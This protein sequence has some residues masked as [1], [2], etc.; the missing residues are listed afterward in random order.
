MEV[1]L[2]CPRVLWRRRRE[3]FGP[4]QFPAVGSQGTRTP[5]CILKATAT[6]G[7][8]SDSAEQTE[9][10]PSRGD[11]EPPLRA[12]FV[13]GTCGNLAET[14]LDCVALLGLPS[15][16]PPCSHW[17]SDFH[18]RLMA[19]PACPSPPPLSHFL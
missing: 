1:E 6:F 12:D 11:R 17:G 13:F 2:E 8:P 16:F 19:L 15:T 10:G 4:W 3:L 14:C 9:A 18:H 7:P 5:S